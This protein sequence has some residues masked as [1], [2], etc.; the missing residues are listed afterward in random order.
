MSSPNV[1]IVYV[2]CPSLGISHF[3]VTACDVAKACSTATITMTVLADES[4]AQSVHLVVD[5]LATS[6]TNKRVRS[7]GE[8]LSAVVGGDVQMVRDLVSGHCSTCR[9]STTS[10]NWP[11]RRRRV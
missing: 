9:W 7:L 11:R 10:S 3:N 5:A 4:D 1:C 2:T 8:R 6:V